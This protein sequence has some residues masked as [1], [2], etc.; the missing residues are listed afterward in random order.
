MASEFYFFFLSS[1]KKSDLGT[2]MRVRQPVRTYAVCRDEDKNEE[3]C[4]FP[5]L[6][7]NHSN[8][9]TRD[10]TTQSSNKICTHTNN[11]TLTLHIL[12]QLKHS[13]D[14]PSSQKVGPVW[15]D[16]PQRRMKGREVYKDISGCV[17]ESVGPVWSPPSSKHSCLNPDRVAA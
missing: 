14:L 15:T 9:A 12:N 13:T 1:S 11:I 17:E 4:F 6:W 16:D 5:L 3:R 2:K 8:L 7:R 10:M